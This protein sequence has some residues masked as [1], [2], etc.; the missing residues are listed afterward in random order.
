MAW[1]LSCCL[2]AVYTRLRPLANC[3]KGD[4]KSIMLQEFIGFHPSVRHIVRSVCNHLGRVWTQRLT[5]TF[6]SAAPEVSI[7][8]LSYHAPL[9]SW[10]RGKLLLIGDAAHPV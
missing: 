8:P 2:G 9:P 1:A 10:H 4:L 5:F 3:E 6:L 7:W